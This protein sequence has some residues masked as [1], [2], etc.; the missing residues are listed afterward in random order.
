MRKSEQKLT[1]PASTK[2]EHLATRRLRPLRLS[3]CEHT[4]LRHTK[5]LP[6]FSSTDKAAQRHPGFIQVP[7]CPSS[8]LLWPS[9]TIEPSSQHPPDKHFKGVLLAQLQPGIGAANPGKNVS[10]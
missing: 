7:L 4:P 2:S 10:Y 3:K 8:P 9:P 5:A 1:A 6:G